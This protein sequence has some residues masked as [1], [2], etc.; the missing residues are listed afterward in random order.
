[1]KIKLQVGRQE[2][3]DYFGV[4]LNETVNIEFE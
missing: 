2:N 3:A 4:S 1:M